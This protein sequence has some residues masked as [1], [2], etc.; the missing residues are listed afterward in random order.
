M[1]N[2][3]RIAV[4]SRN[5]VKI[6]AVIDGA[7][8][9]F[10]EINVDGFEVNSNVS[11]QPIGDEEAFQGAKARAIAVLDVDKNANYGIG[12][13]GFCLEHDEDMYTAGWAV[14]VNREGIIG[15]GCTGKLL[16]PK[17]IADE[18]RKGSELGPVMDKF[19]NTKNIKHREGAVGIF[20][21][22][23]ITRKQFLE[24]AVIL[25]F[26]RFVSKEVYED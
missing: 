7:S 23:L 16:L 10:K 19:T 6:G 13:E 8:K 25:A 24:T 11:H 1:N 9:I 17:K 14:I 26:A 15:K 12:L 4:G 3:I 22:N 20:T 2:K 21:N 18:I 5:P